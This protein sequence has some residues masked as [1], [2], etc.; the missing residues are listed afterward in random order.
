MFTKYE[1]DRLSQNITYITIKD[2]GFRVSLPLT[3]QEKNILKTAIRLL[4]RPACLSRSSFTGAHAEING[5]L[6]CRKIGRKHQAFGL[7]SLT[8]SHAQE[9][10]LDHTANTLIRNSSS[11]CISSSQSAFCRYYIE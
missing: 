8:F 4:V 2:S 3:I 7:V 6:S 5:K 9:K 11:H 1:A 10:L